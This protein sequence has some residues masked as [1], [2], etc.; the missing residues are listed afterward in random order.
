[1]AGKND[2]L[3]VP[4]LIKYSTTDPVSFSWGY[5]VDTTEP[6]LIRGIKLSL[7]P[8]KRDFYNKRTDSTIDSSDIAAPQYQI[9]AEWEATRLHKSTVDIVADY[10]GAV[11]EYAMSKILEKGISDHIKS[12][13]KEFT[14]TVPAIWSEEAKT[15]TLRVRKSPAIDV[16][17]ILTFNR[18]HEK[19]TRI[20]SLVQQI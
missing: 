8:G 19:L 11:Y 6:G 16:T 2:V 18:L 17:Y 7:D 1:M 3:K 12:L 4:S 15:A 20:Y 9:A 10:I 5:E 14:L 13:K